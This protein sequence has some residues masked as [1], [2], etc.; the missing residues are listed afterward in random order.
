MNRVGKL[1]LKGFK[2]F[3]ELEVDFLPLNVLIGPNGSGK[4]NLISFFRMLSW[5][6]AAPRG[7]L[8]S[9]VG[10]MGGASKLLHDGPDVTEA[11]DAELTIETD[12]G[13]NG[14]AFRLAFAAT[15]TLIF[16]DERYRFIPRN[17][18]SDVPWRNGGSGH[19]ESALFDLADG[20]DLVARAIKGFLQQYKVYQFHNTSFTSR[21]RQKWSVHDNAALKE[22]AGNLAPV[23]QHMQTT[24]PRAYRR[25]VQTIR[26]IAPWFLDFHFAVHD[27]YLLLEWREEGTDRIF[28]ASQASDGTL[29]TMALVTL[30]AQP[31]D[32]LPDVLLLDEPELGLHPAAIDILAGMLKSASNQSQIVIATQSATL[33]NSLVPEDVLVIER[34]RRDSVVSR[35]KSA[36]LKEWLDDY[37]LGELWLS[38]ILGGRP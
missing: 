26:M 28:S 20:G 5:M 34:K 4:S 25:I 24:A 14:Y 31:A 12:R 15:D 18:S 37:T 2:T 17:A 32:Q 21:L 38:N 22:D 33:L 9:H 36:D 30:L 1:V 16:L 3:H 8:Q 27:D 7:R 35:K 6:F 13:T 11:I 10:I 19:K 23:L 29:R